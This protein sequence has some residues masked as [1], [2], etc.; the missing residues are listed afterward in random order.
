M[1][2]HTTPAPPRRG[3]KWVRGVKLRGAREYRGLSQ[4]RLADLV[5]TI[6]QTISHYE[7]ED[8]G[9]GPDLEMTC[10]LA[11]AL[12]VPATDLMHGEGRKAFAKLAPALQAA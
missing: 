9:W 8:D 4:A 2:H 7:A 10:L 5:G 3:S 12:R 6:Q 11:I 1:T